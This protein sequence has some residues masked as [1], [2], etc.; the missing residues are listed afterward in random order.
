MA[1]MQRST[2]A[3]LAVTRYL[4][5]PAAH[6][7]DLRR[8]EPGSAPTVVVVHG[9]LDRA[10]SLARLCRHLRDFD[11]VTYD[12]RGYGRSADAGVATGLDDHVDDLAAVVEHVGR[13]VVVFGHS[14]GGLVVMA[15]ASR[16]GDQVL[17]TLTY[18][19]PAHWV[20]GHH[21]QPKTRAV[22]ARPTP[23]DAA[24]EFMRRAIGDDGWERLPPSTRAQRRAEGPALLADLAALPH[25]GP[26]FDPK[27]ITARALLAYGGASED[28]LRRAAQDMAAQIPGA[29]VAAVPGAEHPVHLTHPAE[30]ALLVRRVV[31][32]VDDADADADGTADADD[33][34]EGAA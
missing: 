10:S 6:D 22:L 29:Q 20:E 9:A 5:D 3:G 12:R 30:L 4:P 24:E 7:T 16:L 18:E 23:G 33:A 14:F 8:L 2:V 19:S 15:G 31:A 34:I 21:M 26:S 13:P 11:V 28:R 17:G 25:D 27:A 32:S 1:P